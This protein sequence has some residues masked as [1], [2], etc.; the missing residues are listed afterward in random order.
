[1]LGSFG[2]Q[3]LILILLIVLIIFGAKKLPEIGKALGRSLMEFRKGMKEAKKE[4]EE[5][6]EKDKE[7]KKKET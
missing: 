1:M 5:E 4:L 2:W 3:E 6:E 7:E